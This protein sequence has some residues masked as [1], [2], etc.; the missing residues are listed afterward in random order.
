M[1]GAGR[2]GL[3]H[4]RNFMENVPGA[5]LVAVAD[6]SKEALE[7][8]ARELGTVKLYSSYG[9]ALEDPEVD[10]VC[11]AAPTFLHC[12]IACE[13]AAR[14]KHVFCE[15]RWRPHWKRPIG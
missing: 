6:S 14:G 12:E 10:A 9:R 2:A 13:S 4:A 3:I 5:R 11:I 15:N 1:V 7:N 8:A